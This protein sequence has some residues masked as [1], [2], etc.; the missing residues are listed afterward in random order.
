MKVL[1]FFDYLTKNAILVKIYGI[2]AEN[3]DK[4]YN[5]RISPASQQLGFEM[6][7]YVSTIFGALFTNFS[8]TTI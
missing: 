4:S 8:D 5:L 6:T 2:I 7:E 3:K 1:T